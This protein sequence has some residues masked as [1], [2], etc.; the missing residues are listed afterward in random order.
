ML[1]IITTFVKYKA[2]RNGENIDIKAFL[3][4]SQFISLDKYLKNVL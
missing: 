4:N 1:S 3:S 2:L